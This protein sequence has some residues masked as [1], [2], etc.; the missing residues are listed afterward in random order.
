MKVYK[1]MVNSSATAELKHGA[2][3]LYTQP[4][5]SIK[6]RKCPSDETNTD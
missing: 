4:P 6:K 3:S 2:V 5:N 1:I